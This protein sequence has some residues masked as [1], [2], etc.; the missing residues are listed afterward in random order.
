MALTTAGA[1]VRRHEN[2]IAA[3]VETFV[4]LLIHS[5]K[6]TTKVVT[7]ILNFDPLAKLRV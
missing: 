7:K 3:F 1:Q 6:A 5:T 2:F 4:G